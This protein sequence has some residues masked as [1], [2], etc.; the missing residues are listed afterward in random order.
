MLS[1]RRGWR[2]VKVLLHVMREGAV[3]WAAAAILVLAIV[4]GTAAATTSVVGHHVIGRSLRAAKEF[5]AAVPLLAL[6]RGEWVV[7]ADIVVGND[8][9]LKLGWR[10]IA[11]DMALRIA[12][13]VAT[14]GRGAVECALVLRRRRAVASPAVGRTEVVRGR[15][16][17]HGSGGGAA[18]G[19]GGEGLLAGGRGDLV[20]TR[21][22]A[23]M[24]VGA[25]RSRRRVVVGIWRSKVLDGGGIRGVD[26]AVV[27]V[28]IL[29]F[30]GEGF[31]VVFF[32]VARV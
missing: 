4:A 29:L 10:R 32:F 9:P 8:A 12:R 26:L 18:V 3:S 15:F 16:D 1:G 30:V 20:A 5:G 6:H 25:M 24:R 27:P 14:P 28:P 19:A 17:T 22:P 11:A 13:V 21:R 23:A 31:V 7:A 2:A